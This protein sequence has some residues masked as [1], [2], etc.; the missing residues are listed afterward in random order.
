MEKL[1]LPARKPL[2]EKLSIDKSYGVSEQEN[3]VLGI[4]LGSLGTILAILFS[5]IVVGVLGAIFSS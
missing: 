3:L 5:L 4:V 1:R 2:P